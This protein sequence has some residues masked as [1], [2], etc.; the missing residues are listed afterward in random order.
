[1]RTVSTLFGIGLLAAAITFISCNKE[2]VLD[3]P[4]GASGKATASTPLT[5]LSKPAWYDAYPSGITGN[6][7]SVATE[8]I[9]LEFFGWSESTDKRFTVNFPENS[10]K[11]NRAILKYRMGAWNQGP[12]SYDNVTMI[13][14]KYNNEWHEIT[15]AFTPYGN[16]FDSSWERY[17]YFDVTEYLP[18]LQ[19]ATEFKVYYGGFDATSTRAHTVTLTF[20]LYEGTATRTPVY[21]A[22]VYDSSKDGN[23]G[24]RA[25]AYG[26]AG[27][28]IEAPERVGLRTFSIPEGVDV[29]EMRVAI[30]G[31]GHDLGDFPDRPNYVKNNAAEFVRNTFKMKVDG[32]ANPTDG[33]IWITCG[34][35]YPQAGTCYYDRANWCPGNPLLTQYWAIN[36]PHAGKTLT[37]DFDFE[38]FIST[39]TAPNAEGAAQYIM[40]VDLVGYQVVK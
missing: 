28:D 33:V 32:V 1:M 5:Q 29:L 27:L 39:K 3:S 9:K 37:L 13:A 16:S 15:R 12:S 10:S 14:V 8:A 22:K 25:F 6:K 21:F 26:I 31:H 7:T 2:S 20:D 17:Y 30:S 36:D 40:Q 23:S 38:R 35:N 4:D 11:F 24:Y 19:G 18:M 34:N